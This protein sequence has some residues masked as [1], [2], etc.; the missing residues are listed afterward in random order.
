MTQV[1]FRVRDE[2]KK[3]IL[4]IIIFFYFLEN[5]SRRVCKSSN[6]KISGLTYFDILI[7]YLVSVADLADRNYFTYFEKLELHIL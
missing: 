5:Y 7:F 3:I 4:E 6:K 1:I 2:I